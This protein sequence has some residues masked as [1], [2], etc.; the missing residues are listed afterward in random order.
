MAAATNIRRVTTRTGKTKFQAQVWHKGVFYCSQTFD[1]EKLAR[2]YK[3]RALEQV[4]RGELQP[5]NVRRAA[6]RDNADLARSMSEWAALYVERVKHG[7]SR[8]YDYRLVGRLLCDKRLQDFSGKQGAQLIERLASAWRF[9]RRPR[10]H[11]APG[12]DARA[13]KPL[14]EQTV[15]LRVTALLRLLRFAKSQLGDGVPFELPAMDQLFE[16][17]LP[18]AHSAPRRREPSDEE[19]ARLLQHVGA[20]SDFGQFLRVIDET[21]CRLGEVRAARGSDVHFFAAG[22][23]IVGGY[24]LLTEHKTS[25]KIGAREVPF[26]LYAARVLHARKTQLGD[27]RLFAGLGSKD[28]VCRNFEHACRAIGLADLVIKDMRRAFIN[29]NKYCVAHVDMRHLVGQSTLLDSSTVTPSEKDILAAVGHTSIGTTSGYSQPPSGRTGGRLHAHEPLAARLRA[30]AAGG[31]T[32]RRGARRGSRC[33][34]G[35]RAR[36]HAHRDVHGFAHRCAR[37]LGPR[38]NDP[39]KHRCGD[40][41]IAAT[42]P[43]R[44]ARETTARGRHRVCGVNRWGTHEARERRDRYASLNVSYCTRPRALRL[45]RARRSRERSDRRSASD[46]VHPIDDAH[47]RE[48]EVV[49]VSMDAQRRASSCGSAVDTGCAAGSSKPFARCCSTRTRTSSRSACGRR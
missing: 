23:Q 18:P 30:D 32:R 28:R 45:Q 34:G 49:S 35:R 47:G 17:R 36:R 42:T 40:H 3:K 38:G 25:K 44:H 29:R 10:S 5:A 15:R 19:M 43:R 31:P 22:G 24:L 27:G 7:S 4:V 1:S 13:P 8:L 14:S 9:D 46:T 39:G 12:A 21:G 2:D 16:F 26:S 11:K 37:R 20:E 48:L 41:R 33:S 6:R